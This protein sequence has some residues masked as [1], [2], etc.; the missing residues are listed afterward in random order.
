[1]TSLSRQLN[2]AS[3][4]RTGRILPKGRPWPVVMGPECYWAL[5]PTRG[6][7]KISLKR[8]EAQRRITALRARAGRRGAI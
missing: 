4:R 2:R 7:K 8:V 5:H 1:M 3:A 6:W